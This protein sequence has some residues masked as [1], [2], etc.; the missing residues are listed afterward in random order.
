MSH[1]PLFS[2]VHTQ[3]NS[4]R[5]CVFGIAPEL[6]GTQGSGHV[7]RVVVWFADGRGSHSVP[8]VL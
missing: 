6:L 3:L 2:P 4:E 8:V 1:T 5:I 7:K